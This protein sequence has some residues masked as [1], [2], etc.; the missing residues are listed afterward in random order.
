MRIVVTALAFIVS[1]LA[2]CGDD[3]DCKTNADCPQGR[4]CRVGLC[5][6]DPNGGDGTIADG[7]TLLDVTL[8]CDPAQSGDLV[9]NELLADPPAGADIDGNGSASA[10]DDEFVE[11]VNV[12]TREVALSNVQIDVGGKRVPLGQLCLPPNTARVL[13]G[14][15][16]L[17]TLANSSGRVGL[18]ID[19]VE[20]QVHEYG[21]EGGRDSSLT[22]STQLDPSASWVLHKDVG[23]GPYSPGKCSNGNDFPDC[24]GPVIV[25][26]GEVIQGDTET[27]TPPDCD[28]LPV[29]GDLLVNEL[30]ADPGTGVNGND[31][32]GDGVVDSDDDE[33]VE[34]VN[35]SGSTLLLGG[36][37]MHDAT[38]NSYAF[39]AVC[40]A[41]NQAVVVFGDYQGTGNFAGVI[42][43]N[44]D[45]LSLNNGGDAVVLKNAAGETLS[46]T[47]YG[48]EGDGDQSIVR[49]V[50]LDPVAGF[51]RHSTAAN[52]G[53]A[54]MSPGRCQNGNLFPDCAGG[55]EPVETE[56]TESEVVEEIMSEVDNEVSDV[57]EVSDA[58][59]VSEVDEEVGP[60]CGP[61]PVAGDLVLNEV[62]FDPPA[63]FDAN[64]DGALSTT[65]DEFVEIV[66]VSG[67][68]INLAGVSIGDTNSPTNF[69]FGAV[70]LEAGE[71]VVVY[72]KG[73]QRFTA[74]GM[75]AIDDA[76]HGLSLNNSPP[77]I[78]RITSAG[79]EILNES[80]AAIPAD[81]STTRSPDVSG[82]F[83]SHKTVGGG[84]P[85]S[86]GKCI[87]GTAMPAC[88][89][90]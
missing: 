27:I 21:S 80:F 58:S 16:G 60:S 71:V 63:D 33:F 23:A 40:L 57:S 19:N 81:Q 9:L 15:A 47:T 70:C 14:S 25:P 54:K 8:T 53:G 3:K 39:P 43:L 29:A 48:S 62:L 61:A 38:S 28:V 83:A 45:G 89:T 1:G 77:E 73:A 51:V 6:L 56:A 35:V 7:E 10:N 78:V 20:V 76:R 18:V 13:F 66:N 75:V 41:P 82:T 37:T 69:T 65:D 90:P 44:G 4:I 55:A 30:M 59:D 86:P 32:N 64:G 72:G 22:L 67:G 49:A 46:T 36:L 11:V 5:A 26:D 50:D 34:I 87:A 88:L 42:A 2:A 74:G 17:P 68:A 84:V 52:S 24:A 31:S 12:S 85:A 79:I